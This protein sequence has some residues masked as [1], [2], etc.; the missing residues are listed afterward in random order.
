MN[1][2]NYNFNAQEQRI[3]GDVPLDSHCNSVL[4]INKGDTAAKINGITLKPFPP[5]FPNL[6]GESYSISGNKGEILKGNGGRLSVTFD[7]LPGVTPLV[8]IVQKYYVD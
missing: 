8:L 3:S 5:G 4:V 1:Y 6:S 7:A 2:D